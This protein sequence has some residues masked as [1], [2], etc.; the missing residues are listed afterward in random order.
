MEQTDAV[1]I[2]AD[3]ARV[4]AVRDGGRLLVWVNDEEAPMADAEVVANHRRRT[5]DEHRALAHRRLAVHLLRDGRQEA[6]ERHMDIAAELA[7]MDWT[8]RR[9]L[10]PLRGQ[11]PFGE[12]FF[13]LWEEWEQA[14][15]PGYGLEQPQR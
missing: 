14:G 10:L 3:E 13:E 2:T 1:V 4:R 5:P 11:D 8:I 9:G 7:P 15:R 6:A 12:P